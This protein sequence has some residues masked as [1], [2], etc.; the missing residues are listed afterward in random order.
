MIEAA[1]QVAFIW[2]TQFIHKICTSHAL[3]LNALPTYGTAVSNQITSCKL[4][5]LITNI[6][7]AVY[8]IVN[9]GITHQKQQYQKTGDITQHDIA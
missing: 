5:S 9:G 7:S 3:Q 1:V 2:K 6:S 8:A 4:F